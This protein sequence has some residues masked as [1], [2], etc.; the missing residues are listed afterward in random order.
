MITQRPTPQDEFFL[1]EHLCQ[2][3]E[4]FRQELNALLNDWQIRWWHYG[5]DGRHY[6]RSPDQFI[7]KLLLEYSK[8]LNELNDS[9]A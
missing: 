1:E 3:Q 8:L 2:L 4:D 9:D 6:G 7:S 5:P